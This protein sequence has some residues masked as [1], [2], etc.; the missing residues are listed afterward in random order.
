MILICRSKEE[1]AQ[2]VAFRKQYLG[3]VCVCPPKVMLTCRGI[4]LLARLCL[5]GT[6]A[7]MGGQITCGQYGGS[8][9]FLVSNISGL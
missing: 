3:S 5:L 9:F 1:G 2:F 6:G 7:V 4:R 8:P